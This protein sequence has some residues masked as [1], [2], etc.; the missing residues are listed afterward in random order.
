MKFISYF[1]FFTLLIFPVFSEDEFAD[2]LSEDLE[3]EPIPEIADPLEP[4]NKVFFAVNEYGFKFILK[5]IAIVYNFLT[6]RIVQRGIDNSIYNFHSPIPIANSLFQAN[7]GD[8]GKETSRLLINSTIGLAGFIDVADPL[9]GYKRTN[10][11]ADQTLG[12]AGFGWGIYGHPPL[13]GPG[14]IREAF[15]VGADTFFKPTTYIFWS[16]GV[17]SLYY[18][19]GIYAVKNFNS[20]AMNL[21]LYD[22]LYRDSFDPYAYVKSA[23]IQNNLKKT[24][25]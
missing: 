11:D 22:N 17:V 25:R 12:K 9:L 15:G 7:L 4:M 23:Y 21:E 2:L 3:E 20:I 10:R 8:A 14:S 1:T 16:A 24:E 19:L 13:Y 5:P 18:T 6:P